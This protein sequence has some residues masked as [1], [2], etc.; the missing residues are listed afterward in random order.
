[1][2]KRKE[3]I[4]EKRMEEQRKKNR[5]KEGRKEKKKEKEL[6][7]RAMR[8]KKNDIINDWFQKHFNIIKKKKK[9]KNEEQSINTIRKLKKNVLSLRLDF[10]SQFNITLTIYEKWKILLWEPYPSHHNGL[11]SPLLALRD[12]AA[13]GRPISVLSEQYETSYLFY[14]TLSCVI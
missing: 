12:F 8:K 9:K 11:F 5:K 10:S 6:E 3:R 1:M 4:R 2:E 14:V 7:K 13:R